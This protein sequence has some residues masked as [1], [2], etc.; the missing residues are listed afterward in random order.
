MELQSDKAGAQSGEAGFFIVA[1][2]DSA[3]DLHISH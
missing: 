1:P 3:V 2:I